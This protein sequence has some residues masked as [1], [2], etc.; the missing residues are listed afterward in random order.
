M[1]IVSP[2]ERGH[3]EKKYQRKN[4]NYSR[5]DS[6]E[7][8]YRYIMYMDNTAFKEMIIALDVV[9]DGMVDTQK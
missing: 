1:D 2:R 5:K 9:A 3:D 8:N 7:I 6:D 4:I